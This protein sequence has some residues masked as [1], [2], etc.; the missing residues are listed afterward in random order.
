MK[1]IF[2]TVIV[3][4]LVLIIVIFSIGKT[5]IKF[6]QDYGADYRKS[7]FYKIYNSDTL[8]VIDLWASWCEPCIENL[9][10][11]ESLSND[12]KGKN[13]RFITMSIEKDTL[14]C[15]KSINENDFLKSHDVTLENLPYRDSIY[16][17]IEFIDYHVKSS[18]FKIS[19]KKIPYTAVIKNKKVVFKNYEDD[20]DMD[21]LREILEHNR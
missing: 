8:I 16:S 21:T 18:F 7:N 15:K 6:N 11:F 10:K 1:K 17:S 2:I 14:K 12:F 3:V 13:I 19:S 9:P 20:L 5:E 4:F